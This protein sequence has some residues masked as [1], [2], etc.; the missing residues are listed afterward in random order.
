MNSTHASEQQALVIIDVQDGFNDHASW[1]NTSNKECEQNIETLLARWQSVRWPVVVVRHD[2]AAAASPL[3]AANPGNALMPFVAAAHADLLVTKQVNSAFYGSPDLHSWLQ[4]RGLSRMVLCGIQSNMCVETTARMGGN[5]G[6]DVTVA[7]DATRT[8]DLATTVPGM[9]DIS[10]T[11]E[12]LRRA[13]ALNLQAGRFAR[14]TSTE[15][16]VAEIA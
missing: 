13:T 7:I 5:L 2:S 8:F 12:E 16:V 15:A 6:Y 4:A 11:A 3:H 9:G 1:G 10:L 14:V